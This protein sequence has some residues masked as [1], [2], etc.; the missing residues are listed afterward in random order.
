M[1]TNRDKKTGVKPMILIL[2]V[3]LFLFLLLIPVSLEIDYSRKGADD[4]FRL[5]LFTGL[6]I[7]GFHFKIPYI[8]NRFLL[9]FTELFAEI[10]A[11]FIN[12]WH[13]KKDI[14]LEK[15]VSWQEIQF[16][17]LSRVIAVLLNKQLNELIINTIHLKAKEVSWE[18]EFG[19]ADPALTGISNGLLWFIKCLLIQLAEKR[20]DFIKKPRLSIKPNFKQRGFK[21]SFHGIFLLTIGNIIFTVIKIIVYRVKGGY[22]PWENIQLKN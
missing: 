9:F 8:E 19:L 18:T 2:L 6:R 4:D 14:E 15:E 21:T 22:R 16:K 5:D 12:I 7:F 11:I 13:K 20:I 3:S 17:K 1:G 10:D